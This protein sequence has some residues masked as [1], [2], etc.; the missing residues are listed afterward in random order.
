[1]NRRV[2]VL[3]GGCDTSYRIP[4]AARKEED[5]WVHQ[6]LFDT[7]DGCFLSKD[8]RCPQKLTKSWEGA[9][10]YLAL[11]VGVQVRTYILSHLQSFAF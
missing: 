5:I 3:S 11:E 10:E 1:M 4:L 9:L 2:G 7:N 6:A 8:N